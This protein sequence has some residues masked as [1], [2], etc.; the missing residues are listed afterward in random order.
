MRKPGGLRL[1]LAHY[2]TYRPF[3]S[4]GGTSWQR[5]CSWG[6]EPRPLRDWATGP[7]QSSNVGKTT[8]H[9]T[10]NTNIQS[11]IEFVCIIAYGRRKPHNKQDPFAAAGR[12]GGGARGAGP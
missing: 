8:T 6:Q 3:D 1:H 10:K 11:S 2:L 12:G 5:Y 4:G 9:Q 7:P